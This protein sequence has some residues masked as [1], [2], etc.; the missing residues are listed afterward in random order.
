MQD[1]S[2]ILKVSQSV[3]AQ[4]V[5]GA[6]NGTAVDT[7]GY[8]EALVSVN[9]GT[10]SATGT[11]DVKVQES[12][13]SGSGFADITNAAFTQYTPSNHQ[14]TEVGRIKLVG[15]KRYLRVVATQATAAALGSAD[16]ILCQ[17][18]TLPAQ[19]PS[20]TV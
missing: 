15:R 5:S 7:A 17:A 9:V 10:V 13:A 14:K 8:D 19:T 16:I 4:S 6:V 12:D 1:E 20:W 3:R 11:L 18:K 2:S